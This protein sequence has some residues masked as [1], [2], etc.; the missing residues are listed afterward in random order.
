MSKFHLIILKDTM[1]QAGENEDLR[2]SQMWTCHLLAVG[3]G[4]VR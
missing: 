4:K 3:I 1:F 2:I